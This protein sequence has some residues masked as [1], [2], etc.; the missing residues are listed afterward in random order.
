MPFNQKTKAFGDDK[1]AYETIARMQEHLKD[2]GIALDGEKYR[3]G[4]K[5]NFDAKTE[6][7][8]Q[9]AADEILHGTYR[10]GFEVPETVA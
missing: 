2:N 10:K 1:E 7:T 9:A 5:L 6:K 3:L 8:G 4:L